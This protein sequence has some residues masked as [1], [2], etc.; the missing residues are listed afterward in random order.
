LDPGIS[1]LF[2]SRLQ[3]TVCEPGETSHQSARPKK[4]RKQP[5]RIHGLQQTTNFEKLFQEPYAHDEPQKYPP[6]TIEDVVNITVTPDNGGDPLLFP[7]LILEAKRE[8]DAQNFEQ[9]EIQTGFPIKNTLK[10]QYDLM[11]TRGNTMDVPG[12]PLVWF[13]ASRGEDWRVYGAVINEEEC[14]PNYVSNVTS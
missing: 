4:N 2:S 7:L 12:G 14:R 9:M 10:L 6:R 3:E 1:E 11:K 8:K 5:D 13:F